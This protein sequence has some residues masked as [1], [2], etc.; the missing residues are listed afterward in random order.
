MK[1]FMPFWAAQFIV[2]A[3]LVVV[4]AIVL[5]TFLGN[6]TRLPGQFF[7]ELGRTVQRVLP[8]EEADLRDEAQVKA[9][10]RAMPDGRLRVGSLVPDQDVVVFTVTAKRSAVTAAVVAGDELR[11]SAQSG[12]LEIAPQGIPDILERLGEEMRKL[13]ERFFGGP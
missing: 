9:L 5:I 4:I 11:I 12:E 10:V 3:A 2:G 13:R 1:S 6:A 7:D 8:R